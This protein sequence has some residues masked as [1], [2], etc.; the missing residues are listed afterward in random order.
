MCINKYFTSEIF[1]SNIIQIISF[2]LKPINFNRCPLIGGYY[3]IRLICCK[4]NKYANRHQNFVNYK[5]IFKGT[6]F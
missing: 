1:E 4:F 5:T 2:Y 3:V 6:Y